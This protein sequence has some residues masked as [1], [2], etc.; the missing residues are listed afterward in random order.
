MEAEMRRILLAV[1]ILDAAMLAVPR[2]VCAA[3]GWR[4]LYGAG[5]D[6][7]LF[8]NDNVPAGMMPEDSCLEVY[9]KFLADPEAFVVKENFHG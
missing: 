3:D 4:A 5:S 1:L 9:R 6:N 8:P 7:E 2:A